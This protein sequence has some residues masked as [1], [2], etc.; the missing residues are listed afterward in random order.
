MK[1]SPPLQERCAMI[2]GFAGNTMRKDEEYL[3]DHH[4]ANETYAKPRSNEMFPDYFAPNR[5]TS[6]LPEE[7]NTWSLHR[8]DAFWKSRERFTS[9]EIS[10]TLEDAYE[11][12]N[13]ITPATYDGSGQWIDYHAHFE[14][15]SEINGWSYATKGLYLAASLRGSVQGCLGNIPKGEKPDYDTP[16]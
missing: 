7:Y 15:Y 1:T 9:P 6:P 4:S 5:K 16:V 14:A 2:R 3:C 13:S 10:S 12:Q 8:A 11:A